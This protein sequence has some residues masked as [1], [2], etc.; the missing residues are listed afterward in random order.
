MY[1]FGIKCLRIEYVDDFLLICLITNLRI[2]PI[3]TF[4]SR[5]IT[6]INIEVYNLTKSFNYVLLTNLLFSDRHMLDYE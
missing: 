2:Q 3:P 4:V 5:V 1:I 6:M